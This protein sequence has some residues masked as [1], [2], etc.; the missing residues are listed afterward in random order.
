MPD[1]TLVATVTI[2][3]AT[4]AVV[5][6]GKVP[7]YRIDRAGAALLG[8]SLMLGIGVLTPQEAYCAIDFGTITLLLGVMIVVPTLRV[9]GFFRLVTDWIPTP[10]LPPP[11]APLAIP[12]PSRTLSP[13]FAHAP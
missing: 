10:L 7:V 4:Y 2:F 6:V 9:C 8:G 13:L 3:I 5:A 11:A 1:L 12:L